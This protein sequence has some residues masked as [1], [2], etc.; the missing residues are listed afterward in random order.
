[1]A[2]DMRRYNRALHMREALIAGLDRFLGAFDAVLCP[3]APT[4][5]YSAQA[6]PAWKPP[7]R[8][9]VGEAVLPYFKATVWRLRS[10]SP[11]IRW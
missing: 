2:L 6:M 10:R 1:M 11:A 4:A 9:A 3:V 5:P 8:I 7:P